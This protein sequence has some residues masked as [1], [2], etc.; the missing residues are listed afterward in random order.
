MFQC[1]VTVF[2]HLGLICRQH[3]H[4]HVL[5]TYRLGLALGRWTRGFLVIPTHTDEKEEQ[6][7]G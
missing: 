6:G 4:L 7:D 5:A 1:L 3:G 2:S